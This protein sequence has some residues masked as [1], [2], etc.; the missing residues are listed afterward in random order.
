MSLVNRAIDTTPGTKTSQFAKKVKKAGF[1][2]DYSKGSHRHYLYDKGYDKIDYSNIDFHFP[3]HANKG[4]KPY[5]TDNLKDA[6][7][8]IRKLEEDEGVFSS[9]NEDLLRSYDMIKRYDKKRTYK[10]R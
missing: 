6:V 9:L 2:L 10:I 7:A 5:F 8:E 3:Y 1:K 4:I